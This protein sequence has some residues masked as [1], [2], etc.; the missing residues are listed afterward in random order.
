[1]PGRDVEQRYVDILTT[2]KA[3]V[4][5]PVAVKLA[6]F[7]SSAREA[8]VRLTGPG[9]T[10]WSCSTGSCRPTSTRKP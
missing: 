8:T 2:V 10:G 5:I 1:M 6:P 9:R 3:T 4:S 7:F